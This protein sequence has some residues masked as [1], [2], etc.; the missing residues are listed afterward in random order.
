MENKNKTKLIAF[1]TSEQEKQNLKENAKAAGM[2][3]SE[4]I[5]AALAKELQPCKQ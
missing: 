1:R 3:L 4:L 5:R 2:T